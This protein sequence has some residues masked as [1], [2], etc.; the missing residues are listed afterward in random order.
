MNRIFKLLLI[1]ALLAPRMVAADEGMWIPLLLAKQN[2]ADMKSKGLKLSADEL[3]SLNQTSLKDAIVIFGRGCT[4]ELISQEGLLLTNHHCGHSQI[5]SH[6]SIEND[7][8]TNGFWAYNRSEELVNKGLSV[9]FLINMADIT[10][11]VLDGVIPEMTEKE[12]QLKIRSNSDKIIAKAKEGTHYEAIIRPFYYGNQ[13]FL[14]VQEVFKDVRLVGAPPAAIGKFGGDTDNWMWPRHTGDFALFRVYTDKNGKPAEYSPDNIP[15]QSKHFFKI[16]TQ[17]VK[18][19]DFTMVYGYP[20]STQEYL[21][22]YA[23]KMITEVSNPHKIKIRQE[24]LDV[25]DRGMN[26]DPAVR[27]QYSAKS[28]GVANAWK[29]WIGENRGLKQLNAIQKKQNFEERFQE[30]AIASKETRVPYSM[31]LT[32]LRNLYRGIEETQLAQDYLMEAGLSLEFVKLARTLAPLL[33]LK[34]GVSEAT[35]TAEIEK[36]KK[37]VSAFY[38]DY[39]REIDQQI[40]ENIYL[41][42]YSENVPENFKPSQLLEYQ[43]KY[44]GDKQK[45]SE[46]VFSKSF[47]TDENR[48]LKFLSGYK[49]SK[50]EKL[51]KDPGFSIYLSLMDLYTK[52]IQLP[53]QAYQLKADSLMRVYMR[54]QMQMQED[55]LFY[56]DANFTLRITYGQVK[57]YYP[58]DGVLYTPFT[59]IEGI[60]QKDNPEIYDYNVPEKL[61]D[62][63]RTKDYGIYGENGT[64]PVCFIATNHTTGGNSGSP[65]LNAEGH[66]IG[67]NFDRNWEGTMSDL[68]YDPDRVRNITLDIRYMLFVVDKLAGAKNLMEEIQIVK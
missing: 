63:Y 68:M 13:Y 48:L 42:L 6:S 17:G 21:P 7:Y 16:S 64:L 38:K 57:E 40:F 11:Q 12:R 54:G 53:F 19:D 23:L 9:T 1:I 41:G 61:R 62:L 50:S 18:E 45:Y 47:L 30:W 35:L 14:F 28:A 44:R 5:Q 55:K 33:I 36:M 32:E 3:F 67:V 27:I 60:M 65:V 39:N 24:I 58:R 25:M 51:R 34:E 59:T 49:P 10:N 43:D 37:S 4:G 2:H 31:V 52:K 15:Y 66:L 22:S 46:M 8:L 56:P 20:G 26:A 29:K